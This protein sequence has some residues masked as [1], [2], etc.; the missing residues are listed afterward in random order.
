VYYDSESNSWTK[1]MKRLPK[2]SDV[3]AGKPLITEDS[4]SNP[5]CP[6]ENMVTNT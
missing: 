6:E 5:A 1:K 4:S 3:V 2:N